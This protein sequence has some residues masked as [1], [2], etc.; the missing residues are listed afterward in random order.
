MEKDHE[1]KVREEILN[2]FREGGFEQNSIE[3]LIKILEEKTIGALC[4]GD[5]SE[6][7]K[8]LFESIK[9][10]ISTYMKIY[11]KM[12]LD[13][14]ENTFNLFIS[15]FKVHKVSDMNNEL[16]LLERANK[17]LILK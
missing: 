16:K 11:K 9:S 10:F 7:T 3:D 5:F 17:I 2:I 15:F 4:T 8:S 6:N 14:I 12:N 13:S 1:E